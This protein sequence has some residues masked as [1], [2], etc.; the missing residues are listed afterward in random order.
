MCVSRPGIFYK[1]DVVNVPPTVFSAGHW[2][3]VRYRQLNQITHDV[4]A[5]KIV[6]NF[7]IV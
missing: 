1:L 7:S 5:K 6:G 3:H 2:R 4:L